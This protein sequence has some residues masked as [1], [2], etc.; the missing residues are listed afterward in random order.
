MKLAPHSARKTISQPPVSVAMN[1][2]PIITINAPAE[3]SVFLVSTSK[4]LRSGDELDE[5]IGEELF[6][7]RLAKQLTPCFL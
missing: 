2:P 1:A 4:A 5:V 6:K 7:E 3:P